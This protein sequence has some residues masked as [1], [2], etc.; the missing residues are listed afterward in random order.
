MDFIIQQVENIPTFYD[1]FISSIQTSIK[2][3]TPLYSKNN[4]SKKYLSH[5]EKLL[6][7]KLVLYKNSKRNKSISK[8]YKIKSKEYQLAVKNYNL[9]YEEK[10]CKNPNLK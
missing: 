5:I 9:E 4:K 3:F 2:R 10:F 1:R 6:K 7:E 8:D